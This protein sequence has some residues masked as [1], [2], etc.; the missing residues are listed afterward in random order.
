MPGDPFYRS[1]TWR[2]LRSIV[3]RRSGGRCEVSGCT[4]QG[5]VVDH[6]VSR[7]DGGV[8]NPGNLRHLCRD[9]DNQIKEGADGVRRN[10]GRLK[11]RGCDADGWPLDP[12]RGHG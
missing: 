10:G 1:P 5:V 12:A 8:D 9:H 2:A 7:R 4:R 11:V 3:R 6:I